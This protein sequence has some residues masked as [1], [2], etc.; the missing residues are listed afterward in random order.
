[1]EASDI[2][3]ILAR[4]PRVRERSTV[5]RIADTLAQSWPVEMARAAYNAV[6]LPGDVLSGRFNTAP[7]QPGMWS[8][9]D[10][11]RAQLNDRE[12]MNRAVDLAGMVMGGTYGIAPAESVGMSGANLAGKPQR[13][14]QLDTLDHFLTSNNIPFRKDVSRVPGSLSSYYYVDTPSGTRKFR[15]SDHFGGVGE[16]A[17]FPLGTSADDAF[18]A[19]TEMV[20]R[21]FGP[22]MISNF[23]AAAKAS[24]EQRIADFEKAKAT[25][26]YDSYGPYDYDGAI[27]RWR[28][29]LAQFE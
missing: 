11:A 2:A 4:Q 5:S 23:N 13:K 18:R 22:D 20:G 17:N 9:V 21:E 25:K 19:I 27:N 28:E 1:M 12:A 6:K 15:V 7:S 3:A 10:E 8:D 29:K 16:H 26:S 24:I 14:I